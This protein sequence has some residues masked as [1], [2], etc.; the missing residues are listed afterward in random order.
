MGTKKL[1]PTNQKEEVLFYLKRHGR[2]T[3][4]EASNKLFI[5]DLQSVIRLLRKSMTINDEWVYKKNIY[6]RP[7]R[8]KRYYIEPEDRLN[9]FERLRYFM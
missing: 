2:I 1:L 3:T 8:F 9:L 4:M 5:M 6:G 7:I